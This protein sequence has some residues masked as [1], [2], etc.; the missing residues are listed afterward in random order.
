MLV[1]SLYLCHE[2]NARII[3]FFVPVLYF[4]NLGFVTVIDVFDS[5]L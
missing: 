1:H 5:Y 4:V 3:Y 2:A